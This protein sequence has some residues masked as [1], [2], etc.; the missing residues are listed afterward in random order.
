E[1]KKKV[2]TTAE[3]A[4]T[5]KALLKIAAKGKVNAPITKELFNIMYRGHPA[6][7]AIAKLMGRA[8]KSEDE[9]NGINK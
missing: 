8:V 2:K 1:A 9:K 7:E 3:G 4:E 6:H 5:V